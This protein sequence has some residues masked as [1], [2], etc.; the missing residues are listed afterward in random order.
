M[1]KKVKTYKGKIIDYDELMSRN[2]EVQAVGN[3][4]TNARGDVIDARGRV[5][6]TRDDVVREYNKN[7]EKSVVKSSLL[8]DIDDDAEP[9]DNAVK[10]ESKNKSNESKSN[11]VNEKEE[12]KT[13]NTRNQKANQE[14]FESEDQESPT[15][16]D[17]ADKSLTDA[18]ST[19]TNY[20]KDT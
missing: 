4:E 2:Q 6:K 1:S 10:D 12:R 17:N 16:N 9:L 18:T 20:N 14:S 7:T 3:M 13:K 19:S 5:L 8:D 11:K 15:V